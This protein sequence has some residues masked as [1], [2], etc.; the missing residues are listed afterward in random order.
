MI[1]ST[2]CVC[3]VISGVQDPIVLVR[4]VMVFN[5]SSVASFSFL[6]PAWLCGLVQRNELGPDNQIKAPAVELDMKYYCNL[7]NKG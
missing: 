7:S 2:Y 4:R 1:N 3:A 6:L 5:A